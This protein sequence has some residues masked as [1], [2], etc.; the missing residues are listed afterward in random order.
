MQ[1]YREQTWN[2]SLF[3]C[4][5]DVHVCCYGFWCCCCLY[6][7]NAEKINNRSKCLTHCCM[8]SF[9]S[10]FGCCCLMH[11]VKRGQLRTKYNLEEDVC[12]DCLMTCCCPPC[13]ICQEA[14]EIKVRGSARP[15]II[16]IHQPVVSVSSIADSS[17]ND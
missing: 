5:K 9:M 15:P 2:E 16:I 1:L 13:A 3:G 10:L 7:E 4:F 8:Y 14:R 17:V 12:A 11:T 6:G